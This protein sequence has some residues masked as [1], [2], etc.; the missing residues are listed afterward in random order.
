MRIFNDFWRKLI[1]LWLPRIC[2]SIYFSLIL[3]LFNTHVYLL[4]TYTWIIFDIL[5]QRWQW[6]QQRQWNGIL[7]WYFI[8]S[9]VF[10]S[11]TMECT[12]HTENNNSLETKKKKKHK[13]GKLHG[14]K[15][16]VIKRTM[17]C[18]FVPCQ[19]IY[20]IISAISIPERIKHAT[21]V[22]FSLPFYFRWPI[23]L[24]LSFYFK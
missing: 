18:E 9:M 22:F 15:L 8:V 5:M 13:K 23:F 7:E 4:Y 6:R 2:V 20:V 14:I 16:G 1:G 24:F 3:Y 17:N 12:M 11:M 10:S 21:L 19:S